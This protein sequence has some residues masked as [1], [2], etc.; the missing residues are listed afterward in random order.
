MVHPG[1]NWDARDGW[2]LLA[3]HGHKF[4]SYI[5]V[6]S[7]SAWESVRRPFTTE[8]LDARGYAVR[9]RFDRGKYR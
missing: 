3:E 8:A 4:D 6:T 9:L 5:A 2:D 7:P 1:Q